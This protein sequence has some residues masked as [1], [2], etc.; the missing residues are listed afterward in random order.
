MD[1]KYGAVSFICTKTDDCEASEVEQDHEDIARSLGLWE[2]LVSL[3]KQIETLEDVIKDL[4]E[5]GSDTDDDDCSENG[6]ENQ[7]EQNVHTSKLHNKKSTLQTLKEQKRRL[8]R[9]LK[10]LSALVRNEYSTKRLQQDFRAGLEDMTRKDDEEMDDTVPATDMEER[11]LPP[12]PEDFQ[13]DVYCISANDYLKLEKVKS[14]S[15]GAAQAFERVEDTQIPRLR[16]AVHEATSESNVCFASNFAIAASEILDRVNL[17][18][19][20]NRHV[21]AFSDRFRG[22][23]DKET[24]SLESRMAPIASEFTQKIEGKISNTLQPSFKQGANAAKTAAMATAT[25]WG[26][27]ARRTKHARAPDQNGLHW[28]TYEATM[29]RKGVHKS[30]AAGQIDLNQELCDPMEKEF[31]SDWRLTMDGA[32]RLYLVEAEQQ[33]V[34]MV[35]ETSQAI[36][37][38]L[39]ES[40]MESERLKVLAN[41]AQRASTQATKRAF[42]SIRDTASQSQRSLH[43]SLCPKIADIMNPGYR[44]AYSVQRGKGT[45]IRMKESIG[46]HVRKVE[47]SM[48]EDA[49]SQLLQAIDLFIKDI[50]SMILTSSQAIQ[51]SLTNVYSVSWDDGQQDRVDK[52]N[53]FRRQQILDCRMSLLPD[54]NRLRQAQDELT[55]VERKDLESEVVGVDNWE[56]RKAK[57]MKQAQERGDYFDLVDSDDDD[58]EESVAPAKMPPIAMVAVKSEPSEPTAAGTKKSQKL[59]PRAPLPGQQP[60]SHT[61]R[62]AAA[63][64]SWAPLFRGLQQTHPSASG[65]QSGNPAFQQARNGAAAANQSGWI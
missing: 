4:E 12:L 29:V 32:I 64:H 34:A 30:K 37:A 22:A 24:A 17:C 44:F 43:R 3:P 52:A 20:E 15:D 47:E 9:N 54:I 62:H 16:T 46:K 25:S 35:D 42:Q 40:G 63:G 2:Q 60:T 27:Y 10:A 21:S 39:K 45:F 58:D 14:D 33:V 36:V 8:Q 11:I 19:T 48:F 5:G 23:F 55:G 51:K 61:S 18:A 59:Q 65:M 49:A 56:Q 6:K 38:A 57:E 1:G 28:C 7:G 50:A 13:L 26:S 41:A 53:P 31:S